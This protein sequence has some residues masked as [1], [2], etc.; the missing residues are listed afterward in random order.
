MAWMKRF[1][2]DLFN[3]SIIFMSFAAVCVPQ[4]FA[5]T[6]D[7]PPLPAQNSPVPSAAGAHAPQTWHDTLALWGTILCQWWPQHSCMAGSNAHNDM[8]L[9][10]AVQKVARSILENIGF[11]VSSHD[12]T[13]YISSNNETLDH[14]SLFST[15]HI[16]PV[17]LSLIADY[18][19]YRDVAIQNILSD[20]IDKI[21]DTH[22]AQL[23]STEKTALFAS[24]APLLIDHAKDSGDDVY[25]KK[26]TES[27]QSIQRNQRGAYYT[28]AC[29][30]TDY[31]KHRTVTVSFR[32]EKI[33][34]GGEVTIH[35]TN[36]G[37]SA[38]FS[39]IRRILH[40][41][42]SADGSPIRCAAQL[43]NDAPTCSLLLD[44][45]LEKT[46][47][48]LKANDDRA[49]AHGMRDIVDD[50]D[51]LFSRYGYVA[52]WNNHWEDAPIALWLCQLQMIQMMGIEKDRFVELSRIESRLQK[53]FVGTNFYN[54]LKSLSSCREVVDSR[55]NEAMEALDAS[56]G[57]MY[58]WILDHFDPKSLRKL[59][60][61][62]AK[63]V[64]RIRS[65]VAEQ[66]RLLAMW[67]AWSMRDWRRVVE[68]AGD[69]TYK[70][71]LLA[72]PQ[73]HSLAVLLAAI[74]TH[75][76][77]GRG[78]DRERLSRYVNAM[79][80]KNPS[81]AFLTL[82]VA[83]QWLDDASLRVVAE[84]GRVYPAAL[85]PREAALF[86][87]AYREVLRADMTPEKRASLEAWRD[88][89]RQPS[90]AARSRIERRLEWMK[91]M[92][93]SDD[94]DN[95]LILCRQIVDDRSLGDGERSFFE[96]IEKY[97]ET[98]LNG[99]QRG[100]LNEDTCL[101]KNFVA[102][103]NETHKQSII[104][105]LESAQKCLKEEA[106]RIAR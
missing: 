72:H 73:R 14:L 23:S 69:V 59:D 78:F 39:I 3:T 91:D 98:I 56:F 42:D 36:D 1:F 24:F 80:L 45:A 52:A 92:A 97:V 49:I 21:F 7:E 95:I 67:T 75:L 10:S 34:E 106:P 6:V 2:S 93:Q 61:K 50:L 35:T 65:R 12:R 19:R 58:A 9:D 64:R 20:P 71:S 38:W 105:L 8:A 77:P 99:S 100:S 26:L 32:V 4:A 62:F 84:M 28:I 102:D 57:S 29:Q 48:A 43:E 22:N 33:L 101:Y 74:R 16:L 94:F 70:K 27:Y 25:R 40:P 41:F 46:F 85:A 68:M 104:K 44:D 37:P 81:L 5:Q 66:R 60:K 54:R 82:S 86:Y 63:W 87:D 53:I 89:M 96:E 90:E 11:E 47:D 13:L 31:S 55:W 103:K 79:M 76:E 83:A 51:C 17:M 88:V 15:D 30:Q 18:N